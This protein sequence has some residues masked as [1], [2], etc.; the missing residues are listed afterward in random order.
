MD[1]LVAALIMSDQC[2]QAA[3][4]TYELNRG[5]LFCEGGQWGH[6]ILA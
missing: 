6:R 1:V 3:S 5:C 2:A 4:I